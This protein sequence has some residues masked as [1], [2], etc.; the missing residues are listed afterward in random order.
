MPKVSARMMADPRTPPTTE[1]VT[2]SRNE[3][4]WR[5]NITAESLASAAR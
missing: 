4:E 3:I 2:K 5:P 1:I